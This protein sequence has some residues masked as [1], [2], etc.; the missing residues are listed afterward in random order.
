MENYDILDKEQYD[1]KKRI[2]QSLLKFIFIYLCNNKGKYLVRT[3][4]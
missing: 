3:V 2:F 1:L 4:I